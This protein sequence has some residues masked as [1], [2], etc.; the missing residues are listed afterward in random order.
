MDLSLDSGNIEPEA[1]N[2][3]NQCSA[4]NNKSLNN[5]N[6]N[7]I[8][9]KNAKQCQLVAT[10]QNASDIITG[11]GEEKTLNV[12]NDSTA[13]H[14]GEEKEEIDPSSDNYSIKN[15]ISDH[16]DEKEFEKEKHPKTKE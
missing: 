8:D 3:Y 16:F 6:N 9:I 14:L 7:N 10:G 15:V 1:A 11:N 13:T 4:S 2:K 12:N 5:N